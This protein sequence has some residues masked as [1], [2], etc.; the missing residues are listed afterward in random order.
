[1]MFPLL[2]SAAGILCC[3]LTTL[4]ATDIKPARIVSEIEHTLKMQLI[5]STALIT[6]AIFVIAWVSLPKEFDHI[7]IN[8][9]SKIVKNWYMFVCVACGLWGGLIIGLVTEYYTSNRFKPVQVCYAV[10]VAV[11]VVLMFDVLVLLMHC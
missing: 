8:D 4:I 1:M 2:V 3:L 7:F 9:P 11:M 6:P 10:A 5:I